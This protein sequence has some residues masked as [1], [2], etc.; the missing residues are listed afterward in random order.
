MRQVASSSF[1]LGRLSH[2]SAVLGPSDRSGVWAHAASHIRGARASTSRRARRRTN[3]DRHGRVIGFSRFATVCRGSAR[4]I[5]TK[6]RSSSSP[7]GAPP[8]TESSVDQRGRGT[9]A[10]I[11]TEQTET[12]RHSSPDGVRSRDGGRRSRWSTRRLARARLACGRSALGKRPGEK[13]A[14]Q[15]QQ[16]R[17]RREHRHQVRQRHQPVERVGDVPDEMQ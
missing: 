16:Q 5:F 6:A 9:A 14:L 7:S 1:E 17:D 4:S 13:F 8:A 15:P 12:V 11:V 3:V 2:H 10:P